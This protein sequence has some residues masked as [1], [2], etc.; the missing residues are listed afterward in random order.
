MRAQW[1]LGFALTI[2]GCGFNATP[3]YSPV[4]QGYDAGSWPTDAPPDGFDAGNGPFFLNGEAI[5]AA[6]PPPPLAGGTLLAS[7]HSPGIAFAANPDG[8]AVDVVDLD[9]GLVTWKA[10][11]AA[12]SEPGRLVE[13]DAGL[14]HVVLRRAG[15]VATLNVGAKTITQRAAC[16]APRGIAVDADSIWVA[17]AGGEL[18]ELPRDGSSAHVHVVE[19]D[20]RDV[21]SVGDVLQVTRFRAAET[22][23]LDKAA[24]RSAPDGTT[25]SGSK[26]QPV[27][28]NALPDP[29]IPHVA[30]RTVLGPD[31]AVYG[32]N[33]FQSTRSIDTSG[34]SDGGFGGSPYGGGG[35]MGPEGGTG[36]MSLVLG[37]VS[38][39]S[40]GLPTASII[41][42]PSIDL[43]VSPSGLIAIAA[44]PTGFPMA[45]PTVFV[46]SFGTTQLAAV[47]PTTGAPVAVAYGPCN[48]CKGEQL[49]IQT[50]EPA[51]LL[52]AYPVATTKPQSTFPAKNIALSPNIHDTGFEIFSRTTQAGIAC[53]SC[54]PEGGDDGHTWRFTTVGPRRTQSLRGG[55]MA[56]A[57]FHWNGDMQDLPSLAHEV[58]MHRMGGEALSDAQIDVLAKW[59]D[60]I[61]AQ[62]APSTLDSAAVARGQTAFGK[63]GCGVCHSGPHFTDNNNHFVGTGVFVQAPS[64]VNVGA[65][66]PWMH[67]GCA[68]TL[69]ARFTDAKCGGGAS[70]G[71][72]QNLSSAEL[73]D[74][75]TY[76]ESL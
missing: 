13:D 68:P 55:V 1:M 72:A 36:P 2:G 26:K 44:M 69:M 33:Q 29:A 31:G 73:N 21:I 15:A 59:L 24:I 49:L 63:G 47:V 11:L 7:V 16:P 46:V 4:G 45:V 39:Y 37:G 62:P 56:T 58:F 19:R 52:V 43:A 23:T 30:R 10:Q 3:Y 70:H 20:L 12:G 5:S 18:V 54:H 8:D 76:L 75:V 50:R 51:E 48:G 42:P 9:A 22:I 57:P 66:A 27:A 74:L 17:C 71:A 32:I 38:R 65:R 64:L 41:A 34:G 35:M 6:I 53:M 40:D 14:V 28:P 25:I 61:P 67:D 60:R